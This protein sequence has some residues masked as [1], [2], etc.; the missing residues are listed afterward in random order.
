MSIALFFVCILPVFLAIGYQMR[1]MIRRLNVL[2]S[3]LRSVRRGQ[4]AERIRPRH[5]PLKR[6]RELVEFARGL[7]ESDLPPKDA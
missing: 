6:N 5:R 4:V 1:R 7:Q 3:G 2:E